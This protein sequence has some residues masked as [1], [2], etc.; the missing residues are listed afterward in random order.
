MGEVYRAVDTRLHRDV[1]VKVLPEDFA[2]DADRRARFE[3]EAQA[4]AAISHPNILAVFDTGLDREHMFVVMELLEGETLRD[5][6]TSMQGAGLPVRKAV[7][8]ATRTANGLAAAHDKGLVH[9]DLKPEN[10][11]LLTG[12]GVKILDFGLARA[13]VATTGSGVAETVA[14]LTDPGLVMGTVGY[15]AP[16]QVRAQAVDAR[17]DLFALGAVLFEMLTGR[18]AFSGATAADTMTAVLRE[19]P[20]ELSTLRSDLPPA[21]ARVVQ[22]CLEKDPV[23]RFQTA[24]DVAFA[25]ETMSGAASQTSAASPAIGAQDRQARRTVVLIVGALAIAAAGWT[26]GRMMRAAPA[27]PPQFARKT[28]DSQFLPSARFL[29]DGRTILYSGALGGNTPS[30]FVVRPDDPAPQPIGQEPMHLLAVSSTGD[31]AVLRSPEYV[32]HLQY[33]GTLARMTLN[34]A[35]RPIAERVREADW[36]PDGSA[37]AIVRAEPNGDRLEYPI[38]T[39]LYESSGYLSDL[40]ISP[41][42]SRVA[43]AD[44]TIRFDNR[45][46]VRVVDRDKQVT[47]L[48]DEFRGMNGLSWTPDGDALLFSASNTEDYRV[49]RVAAS[50]GE[51]PAERLAG[52]GDLL[53]HDVAPN[54]DWLVS[55]VEK[56]Y[57]VMARAGADLPERDVSYLAHNWIPSLTRDGRMMLFTNGAPFVGHD[58]EAVLRTPAGSPVTHLGPGGGAGIS[59]DGAWALAFKPSTSEFVLYPTGPGEVR[60]IDFKPL[61][62]TW[63]TWFPDSRHL[64]AC[65]IEPG[66]PSRCFQRSIDGG[67]LTRISDDEMGFGVVMPDGR[68]VM[69]ARPDRTIAI[70]PI[71]GGPAVAFPHLENG[72]QV[73]GWSN[74]GRAA[75]IHR[76]WDMP[77]R[78]QRLDLAS[79]D[80]RPM[81]ALM[82]PNRSGVV[83]VGPVSVADDGRVYA[84]GF[85]KMLGTLYVVSNREQ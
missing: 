13:S 20:P 61:R 39:V 10:I 18:R 35:P 78:I 64:L 51:R 30:L 72:E 37:L 23:E 62:P 32:G 12:G 2:R 77:I 1:A 50:G 16:E 27:G 59:P 8:I 24:R 73:V 15:M 43:F 22:H 17:A 85:V 56:R 81:F 83:G 3:R 84:Y 29:R 74:D 68:R 70:W 9:R 41:D 66:Q 71:G 5:R 69:A 49:H 82:P 46:W 55:A 25:L 44:H 54:G 65:G 47:T 19:D 4:V 28:Y 42:G 26:A 38:G 58:Y 48:T 21:L 75:F 14:A 33:V 34:G 63:V 45:G 57:G 31:L 60:P 40:R 36:S 53:I 11:F 7:E 67:P 79:G 80:R 76:G 6:L 52:A